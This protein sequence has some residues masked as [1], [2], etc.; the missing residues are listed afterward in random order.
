MPSHWFLEHATTYTYM[1]LPHIKGRLVADLTLP[2]ESIVLCH[3]LTAPEKDIIPHLDKFFADQWT[4][5]AVLRQC[6]R[7]Y[8]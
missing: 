2:R 4:Y 8:I 3:R 1:S 7:V 5:C 6:P